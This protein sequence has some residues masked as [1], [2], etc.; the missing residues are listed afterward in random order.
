MWI[1]TQLQSTWGLDLRLQAGT[2]AKARKVH[3]R[4]GDWNSPAEAQTISNQIHLPSQPRGPRKGVTAC[5][6][7]KTKTRKKKKRE[8][9]KMVCGFWALNSCECVAVMR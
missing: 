9:P 8:V 6:L 7:S 2:E 1:E 3:H 5:R 4:Q